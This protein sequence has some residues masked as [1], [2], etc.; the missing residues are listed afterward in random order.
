[1]KVVDIFD[2]MELGHFVKCQDCVVL[3]AP[4]VDRILLMV[5]HR[6]EATEQPDPDCIQ[7]HGVV[8]FIIQACMMAMRSTP[9]VF[10]A[11]DFSEVIVGSQLYMNL[12]NSYQEYT[13]KMLSQ[14]GLHLDKNL[15]RKTQRLL[16]YLYQTIG[17]DN[18]LIVGNDLH[19]LAYMMSQFDIWYDYTSLP[20]PPM[21]IKEQSYLDKELRHLARYFWDNF[22]LITWSRNSLKRAWCC[23]E[24]VISERTSRRQSVFSAENSLTS[25]S[26]TAP[27]NQLFYGLTKMQ[28]AGQSIDF[29][30]ISDDFRHR[31]KQQ[32]NVESEILRTFNRKHEKM[33]LTSD[34]TGPLK[35][36]VN[37]VT[38]KLKDKS[39]LE[40]L[41][42]LR[43]E[44]YECT[45]DADMPIIAAQLAVHYA[46]Q[47]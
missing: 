22:T 12:I 36:F 35:E 47:A 40:A 31:M 24:A 8:R 2:L 16:C 14:S 1:M 29:G 19:A 45:N 37:E 18:T 42:Y 32:H 10:N 20:Q 30:E 7:F 17:K 34:L 9:N 23:L 5:S 13:A 26:E 38:H 41:L 21:T 44:G 3:R 28:V 46:Q 6:W 11:V 43:R 15:F 25:S 33:D 4:K 27:I 39:K